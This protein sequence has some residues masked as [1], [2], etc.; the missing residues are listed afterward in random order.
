MYFIGMIFAD[1]SQASNILCAGDQP[2]QALC[3]GI[4]FMRISALV[5]F[6][7]A[8]GWGSAHAVILTYD[9]GLYTTVDIAQAASGGLP[10]ED[11]RYT[12]SMR[13]TGSITLTDPLAPNLV[14]QNVAFDEF[15]FFDGLN[16]YTQANGGLAIFQFT[17]DGNS[18]IT[19]FTLFVHT[20]FGEFQ[21][22]SALYAD[23]GGANPYV[24]AENGLCGPGSSGG[25]CHYMELPSYIQAAY[26]DGL[27]QT[28]LSDQDPTDPG[29]TTDIPAPSGMAILL[30]GMA[31]AWRR[32]R[33]TA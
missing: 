11:K 31:A 19:G 23:W 27:S 14:N 21:E 24:Y 33:V 8:L 3:R 28:L 25:G 16:S 13:V 6:L 15:S 29:N 22:Y 4:E 30:I 7:M 17:T 20:P 26:N 2:K 10:P 12:T 18:A 9:S 1:Q 5:A 32:F